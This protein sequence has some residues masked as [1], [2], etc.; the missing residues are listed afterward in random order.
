M[1]SPGMLITVVAISNTLRLVHS[2]L[3]PNMK[4]K[5]LGF[6]WKNLGPQFISKNH[7]PLGFA[8]RSRLGGT[9]TEHVKHARTQTE[10]PWQPSGPSMWNRQ[11]SSGRGAP[12]SPKG[13]RA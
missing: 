1:Y 7:N 11:P 12:P 4:I 13:R 6:Y 9:Q 8:Q 5:V 3:Y 2:L 10:R